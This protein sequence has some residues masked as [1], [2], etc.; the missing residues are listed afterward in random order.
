VGWRRWRRGAALAHIGEAEAQAAAEE[1]GRAEAGQRTA[2]AERRADALAAQR[3]QLDKALDQLAT[4]P[5]ERI[6]QVN[7]ELA[8]SRQRLQALRAPDGA[9]ATDV[10][11][12]LRDAEEI[13][14]RKIAAINQPLQEAAT[15]AREAAERQSA[16]EQAAAER[17]FAANETVIDDLAKQLALFGDERRQ[18]VDQ[19]LSRLSETATDEQ[20]VQVE[21]LAN[22]LYDE[23][24]AR[25][26]LAESLRAEQQLRQQGARLTEQMRTP[27]E[28]LAA[29]LQQ[30]DGLM[31]AGAVD[32]GTHGRAIAEAYRAAEQAADRMLASSRDWQDGV[33][34][35]LRDYADQA[36]DAASAAEQVTTGAFQGME[37]ALVAFV[38]TDKLDF[39]SLVDSMIA[40][41]TRLS[42]RMAI[43]GPL[44]HALSGAG[45][46]I[47]GLF[48]GGLTGGEGSGFGASAGGSAGDVLANARGN[49]FAS[50][51]VIPFAL[52]GVVER[53]TLFP[54]ANGMGLMG[55][56]GPEAVLPLRRLSSGRLGV[57]G[58]GGGAQVVVNIIN[59]AGAR[60]TTEEQQDREGR[61]NLNVVIDALEAA[62]AQRATR[63]GSTL[64]RA[65]VAAANPVRAR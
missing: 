54:M 24:L 64:N 48:G 38:Q 34:R 22:A 21:R 8:E 35:A 23:K 29:A 57:E 37:D 17:A 39:A 14:R 7:R 27:A 42:I 28:E 44:G 36:T 16:A 51:A 59:N 47:S 2:E 43:L 56:A 41:L 46:L 18:F 20:W 45:G 12:A 50:G 65:L 55:E 5:A 10:D 3:S 26:Q 62:M 19:A 25:E 52:G 31:R 11:A 53:P 6:A 4:G 9:N 15:R 33:T 40:D 60:V 1:R 32:A 13:A 30:L 61:L 63:S 58:A 49:A